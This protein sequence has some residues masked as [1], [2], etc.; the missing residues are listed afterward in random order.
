MKKSAKHNTIYEERLKDWRNGSVVYQVI[1]DR[2]NQ[3]QNLED[4]KQLYLPPKRLMRWNELPTPGKLIKEIGYFAHELDYW[5]GDL[6]SLT[7]KLDYIQSLGA[8]VLYLNPIFDSLSNH[9]YDASDYFKISLEYGDSLDLSKLIDLVH[10]KSMKIVL[11]GVFNHVGINAP[12]FQEAKLQDSSKRSWFDFN[13][14]YPAGVRMWADTFSLP[15]LNLEND[16]VKDY[17]F[18]SEKSVI[19][20]YLK[21]GIDGWRLDVAFDIGF[22]ILKDLTKNAHHEKDNCLIVGEIWNYPKK[23]LKSIDGVM[24]FTFRE[25]ILK[26]ITNEIK[27][28]LTNQMLNQMIE[29]TNYDGLLKSWNLLDNHDTPRLTYLVKDELSRILATIF[30]FTLPGSPNLYYGSELGMVGGGDPYNRAPMRWDL[31]DDQNQELQR[32]KDLIK[33]HNSEIALK[34]GDF[35]SI[36]SE[37]FVAYERY[38]DKVEDTCI[39]LINP[40]TTTQKDTLLIRDSKL[41]N[42]SKFITLLGKANEVHLVAGLLNIE[43]E[44]K[45]FVIL[46]PLTSS[47]YRYT[48]YKRVE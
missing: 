40:S 35:M 37:S 9:K 43:I 4:K 23:W 20:T 13:V 18:R 45:G 34:V 42:F 22:D 5:G 16:E 19:K 15:E 12:L 27:P 10:Q 33:I 1:V 46:K 48:P 44:A 17:I 7:E 25:I 31:V 6:S 36:D 24:N 28:G 41:M 21:Q 26:T 2:F 38:T 11:D 3:P 47:P 8:D 30:Q 32:I 39:I 29:D 14:N